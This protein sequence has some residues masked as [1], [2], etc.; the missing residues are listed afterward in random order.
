MSLPNVLLVTAGD[1]IDEGAP[2]MPPAERRLRVPV[3]EIENDEPTS[4]AGP[5]SAEIASYDKSS[6]VG[7]NARGMRPQ[8]SIEYD[9]CERRLGARPS[10]HCTGRASARC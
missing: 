4:S 7:G 8:L 2:A 9:D 5:R 1:G 3:V 10:S 6:R